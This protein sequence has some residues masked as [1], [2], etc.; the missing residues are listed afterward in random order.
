MFTVAFRPAGLG[1]HD[2]QKT[3][4]AG[5]VLPG[6]ICKGLIWGSDNNAVAY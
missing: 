6:Q 4:D 5:V 1:T 3:A 2:V